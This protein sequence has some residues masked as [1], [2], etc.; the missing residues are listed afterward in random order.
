MAWAIFDKSD[1]LF[2]GPAVL[3]RCLFVKEGTES[4][5]EGDVGLFAVAANVVGLAGLALLQGR[6]EGLAVVFHVEPV[7]D[8]EAIAVDGQFFASQGSMDDKGDELL[9]KLAGTVVVG[10]VSGDRR[11]AVGVMVG[12]H[13]MVRGGFGGRV[14]RVGGVGGL[15]GKEALGTEGA[16]DLVGR[17]VEKA[18]GPGLS[19]GQLFPVAPRRLEEAESADDVGLDEGL[20]TVDGAINVTF[21]GEV[22]D[23]LRM[24]IF[25]ETGHE[26]AVGDIAFDEGVAG[27]VDHLGQGVNVA[28]VGQFID[29]GHF[30]TLGEGQVNEV[31]A[32]EA[33]SSSDENL[34][35]NTPLK[36]LRN[37]ELLEL[38]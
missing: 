4:A 36:L 33:G 38:P 15:F 14:G 9:R 3:A 13:Q 25:K 7:A 24:V 12:P 34:Q 23:G 22:H 11:Q 19:F 26:F 17:D 21:G 6:E 29:V 37:I 31:A 10:A 2:V 27:M 35:E 30:V 5:D 8:V 32:D 1:L 18:E 16:V 20:G 28:G